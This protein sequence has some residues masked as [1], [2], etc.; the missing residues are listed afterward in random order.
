MND[1]K[2]PLIYASDIIG[3]KWKLPILGTLIY[4]DGLHYSELKRRVRGITNTMLTKNLRELETSGLV[5]RHSLG[6]VPPSVTYHLTE[7]GK[8]LIPAMKGLCDWA[9]EH[10]NR[11]NIDND[12]SI[13]A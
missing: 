11:R 1:K 10:M 3:S 7:D 8:S 4:E 5:S 12:A 13:Q 2:C 9:A 6:S